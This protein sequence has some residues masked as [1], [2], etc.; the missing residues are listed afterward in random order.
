MT[1]LNFEKYCYAKH[2]TVCIENKNKK[3]KVPK[4]PS[5]E[6]FPS[7]QKKIEYSVYTDLT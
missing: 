5:R 7:N 1:H 2:I 4:L 3:G 6:K